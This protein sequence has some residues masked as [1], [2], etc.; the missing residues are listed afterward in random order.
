MKEYKIYYIIKMN[1][2]SYCYALIVQAKNA[3]EALKTCSIEVFQKT[4]RNCFTPSTKDPRI[5]SPKVQ[6]INGLPPHK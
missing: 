5:N 2:R 1:S 4:G 3:K 6:V